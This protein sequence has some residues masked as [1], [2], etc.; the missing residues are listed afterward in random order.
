[1]I[2][3]NIKVATLIIALVAIGCVMFLWLAQ[4][5]FNHNELNQLLEGCKQV[6]GAVNLVIEPTVKGNY[7]FSC[8]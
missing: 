7:A 4:S 5:Y 8:Q 6:G 1:M 2:D 3:V